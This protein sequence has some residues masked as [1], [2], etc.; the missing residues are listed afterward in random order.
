MTS[1]GRLY[2]VGIEQT[3]NNY[4]IMPKKNNYRKGS[5]WE[6]CVLTVLCNH[7]YLVFLIFAV[8][9]SLH[10]VTFS[11]LFTLL[12]TVIVQSKHKVVGNCN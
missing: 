6:D 4:M 9:Q 1:D 3:H 12:A 7:P 8:L 5:M 2:N 11:V 10:L